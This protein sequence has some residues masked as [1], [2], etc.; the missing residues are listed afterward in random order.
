MKINNELLHNKVNELLNKLRPHLKLDGGNIE[1]NS[2]IQRQYR[3]FE[4][5]WIMCKCERSEITFKYC[6]KEFFAQRNS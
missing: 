6:I 1:I 5:D 4:M 2:N 3:H